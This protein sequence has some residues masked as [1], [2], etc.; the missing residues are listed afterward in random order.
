VVC[1]L[2]K[3]TTIYTIAEN[4]LAKGDGR[5]QVEDKEKLLPGKR[6]RGRIK[7]LLEDDEAFEFS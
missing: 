6:G 1:W 7:Q 4:R 2:P 3:Y 5:S